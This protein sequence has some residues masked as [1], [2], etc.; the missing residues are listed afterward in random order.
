MEKTII[1]LKNKLAQQTKINKKDITEYETAI[2]SYL[3]HKT[4]LTPIEVK[5][6][7]QVDLSDLKATSA[8]NKLKKACDAYGVGLSPISAVGNTNNV[9]AK[10][11]GS[12]SAALTYPD[13]KSFM[14]LNILI[15]PKYLYA[16][17]TTDI[18]NKTGKPKIVY[19]WSK[20][21]PV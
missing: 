6:L 14:W 19:I 1:S 13:Y 17:E 18:N 16:V 3:A 4:P 9:F 15:D 5:N 20:T 10:I 8:K 12:S 11:F 2:A 21:K 7:F